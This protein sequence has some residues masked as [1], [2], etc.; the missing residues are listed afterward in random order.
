MSLNMAA[1]PP[2]NTLEPSHGVPFSAS[3]TASLIGSMCEM[4]SG[5]IGSPS[6]EMIIRTALPSGDTNIFNPRLKSGLSNASGG[7]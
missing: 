2:R 5:D 7:K 1:V 6:C 3:C 4:P